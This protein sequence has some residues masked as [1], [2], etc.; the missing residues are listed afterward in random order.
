MYTGIDLYV[1]VI[2]VCVCVF[3]T[4]T[5]ILQALQF[6]FLDFST[7]SV[8]EYEHYEVKKGITTVKGGRGR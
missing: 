5:V 1:D 4:M 6:G 3:Y 2:N 7:F 8:E